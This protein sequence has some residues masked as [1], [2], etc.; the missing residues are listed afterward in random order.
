MKANSVGF[1]NAY[2][3]YCQTESDLE[4]SPNLS[5]NPNSSPSSSPN[6]DPSSNPSSELLKQRKRS[7]EGQKEGK[8][9]TSG[10]RDACCINAFRIIYSVIN[11]IQ[12]RS[13]NKT[14]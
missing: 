6:P 11:K 14:E 3:Y 2:A 5:S 1:Q 7:M 12:T 9:K 10:K 4:P 8:K 13:T